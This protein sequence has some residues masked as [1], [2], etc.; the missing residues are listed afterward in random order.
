MTL[1]IAYGSKR[2][3]TEGLA[4]M[5]GEALQV[6][7][8]DTEVRAAHEVRTVDGYDGVVVAGALYAGRWHRA[9]RR[10]VRR[11]GKALRQRPVWLVS[12]GPL[13]DSARAGTI[14]PVPQVARA[15]AAVAARGT[16]TFGGRLAADAKGFPA[17]AMAKKISG[18]WRDPAQ[19]GEFADTVAAA[20]APAG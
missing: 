13:D 5:I 1:L 14:P 11:Q 4:M 19:V 6:R 2:G 3:G 7:G 17:S 16:V 18:D 9:A 15:G 8:V 10:L 20:L 12:S